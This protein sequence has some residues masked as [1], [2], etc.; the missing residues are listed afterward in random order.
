MG[1]DIDDFVVKTRSKTNSI[2]QDYTAVASNNYKGV[3]VLDDNGNLRDTYDILLDIAKVYEEI[4]AEDKKAGTNRAQALIEE[5]AGKNRSNIA[6]SIL[7]NP[8]MLE[9]VYNASQ[10]SQGSAQR[11]LSTYLDSIE[12]KFAKLQN[13]LQELAYTSISSDFI[14]DIVDGLTKA[15]ELATK[16][17]D[18]IGVLPTILGAGG[19]FIL[20]K[21]GLGVDSF[22]KTDVN[23]GK[24]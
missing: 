7:M 3:S 9:D 5:L 10:R 13:R 11:E 24:S 8:Q 16:L 12:A 18:V 4:Q 2:I 22:F 23:T 17:V 21:L 19:G 1:E 6:A 20:Q 14:K 15:V